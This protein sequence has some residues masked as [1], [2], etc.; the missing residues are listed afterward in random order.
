MLVDDNAVN[1]DITQEVLQ[2]AGLE[3]LVAV[4]GSDALQ[5]ARTTHCDLV[6]MDVQMPV[7][8]GAQATRLIRTLP[9]WESTP[10]LALTAHAFDEDRSA[11]EAAGMSDF[12]AKPVNADALY[13]ALLSWLADRAMRPAPA[14]G[15]DLQHR[16]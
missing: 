4:D 8:D 16:R 12:I 5:K 13:T 7:L 3:V 15:G 14:P 9:G 1:R 11:C 6:L 10:I 2:L